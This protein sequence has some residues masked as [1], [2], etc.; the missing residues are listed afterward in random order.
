[1]AT[2]IFNGECPSGMKQAFIDAYKS[3][4][5]IPTIVTYADGSVSS[6]NIVGEIAG[7]DE[8]HYTTQIPNLSAAVVVNIGT[9]VTSIVNYAFTNYNGNP[10]LPNLKTV[11][12]PDSVTYIGKGAFQMYQAYCDDLELP[13]SITAFGDYAFYDYW[14][15]LVVPSSVSHIGNNAFGFYKGSEITFEGKT[16]S[17]LQSMTNYDFGLGMGYGMT[18]YIQVNCSDGSFIITQSCLLKGT[19]IL[20]ADGTTKK[21]EDL[22]YDDVL[23]VWDFDEGQLG[24]AKVCWL[25][26]PGLKSDHYYQL[27]FDNGTVLKT[28]GINSNHRIFSVDQ[29]KFTNVADAKVGDKVFSIDGT[30]TITDVQYIEEE[31]EYYNVMTSGKINCFANGILTSDRYGNLYPI[32]GMKYVKDD[33]EIKPYSLYEAAGIDRYW[34][35]HLRLGEN[36]ETVQK[37]KEYVWK[38][39]GQMLPL[40]DSSQN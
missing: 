5:T 8:F 28:T 22:A 30:L 7:Q 33:R 32:Q 13:N 27:T 11:I 18:H 17:Q 15:D 19:D 9:D 1:M 12:I 23:K 10:L 21:I 26:R 39:I 16:I 3:I 36:T 31:C 37:S 20:L 24:S 40:P 14:K 38:C 4:P 6:F 29:S 25:T 34:Y 35:D 2:Y